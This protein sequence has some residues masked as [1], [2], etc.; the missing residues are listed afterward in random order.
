[1]K[2]LS[3]SLI[4]LLCIRHSTLPFSTIRKHCPDD[5]PFIVQYQRIIKASHPRFHV[6]NPGL[7]PALLDFA[8][9]CLYSPS[10]GINLGL[11]CRMTC[12]KSDVFLF[13]VIRVF[14]IFFVYTQVQKYPDLDAQPN[15][16]YD[17]GNSYEDMAATATASAFFSLFGGLNMLQSGFFMSSSTA[18][19]G[20]IPC[21]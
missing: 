12:C 18:V 13:W 7:G 9:P 16:V 4:R 1:M 14:G 2:K 10:F 6:G 20:N 5:Y 11:D 19:R 17:T 21:L 8:V 15:F 3:G